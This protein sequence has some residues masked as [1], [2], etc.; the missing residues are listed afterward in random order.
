M[1]TLKP[2]PWLRLFFAF[3]LLSGFCWIHTGLRAAGSPP[4]APQDLRVNDV[5]DP[6]GAGPDVYFGWMVRDSDRDEVQTRY[7]LLVAASM[8][9]LA[10]DRA[11]VWDS[12]VV[13]GSSQNHVAY[14]G[15]RLQSG[16]RY[17]WRV[18]T[19]DRE[20]QAGA[21][22][23][24][25]R[26][27]TG[28]FANADWAEARWIRRESNDADDY[29]Y[30]RRKV[31]LPAVAITRAIVYLS[32]THRYELRVNGGLVGRGP[33]YQHPQY[34][35]YHAHD[36]TALLKPGAENQLAVFTH[37]F[38]GGQG[39]PAGER[40][41]ILKLVVEH[42]D[43]TESV[44]GSDGFWRQ[45]RAEAWIGDDLVHRNRGEGVGYVERMDARK[46][47]RDWA[48]LG[49]DDS[50]WGPAVEVGAHPV[51]PWTGA[52]TPDLTRID[53]REIAP[54]SVRDFGNGSYLV[55]LGKIHAGR[56][57]VRF[58]GGAPGAVV[59]MRGAD[60]LPESGRI[61]PDAKS[62]ATL[63]EYQAILDGGDF[64]FE[65][66]EYLGMRYFQ[67]DGSPMP[68]T[69]ENVSF[70]TRHTVLDAAASDFASADTAL[71][72]AWSLMK[73]SLFTC[74][75]EQFVD[76]PTREKGGFLLDGASQ[77]TV[78]MPVL[79]ERTLTRRALGEFFRSMDQ[80]WAKPADLGRVNAVYPNRDG[81]R[82]IP[83]FTQAF[84]VWVW[85]YYLETGDL[86]LLRERYCRLKEIGHYLER[87]IDPATGLVTNL[88]GGAGPYQYGI[89]DWP[90]PMRYGFDMSTAAR[91]PINGR[92]FAA[93][94]VLARM[95]DALGENVD[96]D[97]WRTRAEAL[98]VA[99]NSRLLAPGSG[100][101]DGLAADGSPSAHASQHANVFPLALGLVPEANRAAVL[102]QVRRQGMAVGMV[103]V[104]W[105]VR[106]LGENDQGPA[107]LE[108]FTN[109][110]QPGWARSLA[111][112]ATA[113]WE[114]WDSD[115][116]RDESLSHAWG[117]IGL[118]GH[119]HYVL[120]VRPLEPQYAR[121]LI[122]PLDFGGRL[123]WARGRIATDR[124]AIS[125]AWKRTD[126]GYEL[127]LSL[128]VNV[129]A[130]VELPASTSAAP[131]VTLDGEK[132]SA[133]RRGDRIVIS[134]VGSGERTL[135]RSDRG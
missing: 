54:A 29:T 11:D 97:A 10:P 72:A 77:S 27:D 57:Q 111:R 105:L 41:L 73:H 123:P 67:I 37:W 88:T 20:G 108:L 62:Q 33:A 121:V 80:H 78:A 13:V 129:M 16:R 112:G 119:V 31:H 1:P 126:S 132:V 32:A 114:S 7:Q 118:I 116:V 42:A 48:G 19:W 98:G 83:D 9:R 95:A 71:D 60:V 50:R 34:Q 43:G 79:R 65:P 109:A 46:F 131:Q 45:S 5:A 39:R 12:G 56:P 4:G 47:W 26:F 22:S 40:G 107:L 100:Y 85:N 52:L 133:V 74:A 90:S 103:T 59:A 99:I 93:F 28:L 44:L 21:W 35:Y 76:T 58:S 96:R 2:F 115:T 68:V 61:P 30:F 92:A 104:E 66:V 70:V 18:R 91:A 23:A 24:P 113:T 55:D 122:K 53:E 128:P 130:D 135:V 86:A 127:R 69:S 84:P 8:E 17:F 63:M 125:V 110:N 3:G 102:D 75:Q 101:V 106:A 38:G 49:F 94:D 36:V 81:G 25:A 124:G 64:T 134:G 6:V 120:G 15:P 14:A 87:H 51:A 117:A 89:I 82:D